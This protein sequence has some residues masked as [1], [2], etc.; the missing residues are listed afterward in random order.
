MDGV[1]TAGVVLAQHDPRVPLISDPRPPSAISSA[2]TLGTS[3]SR[4][5]ERIAKARGVEFQAA[6]KAW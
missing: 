1:H 5:G 6:T 3:G 2:L 4:R